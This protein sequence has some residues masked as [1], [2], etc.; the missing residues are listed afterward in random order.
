MSHEKEYWKHDGTVPHPS[1]QYLRT[2]E[3]IGKCKTIGTK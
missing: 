1:Y 2:G 3:V